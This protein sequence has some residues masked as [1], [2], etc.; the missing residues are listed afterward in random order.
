M[1]E[2]GSGCSRISDGPLYAIDCATSKRLMGTQ[3]CKTWS[4]FAL[5]GKMVLVGDRASADDQD[6]RFR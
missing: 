2:T 1:K 3:E 4:S 6:I 5:S